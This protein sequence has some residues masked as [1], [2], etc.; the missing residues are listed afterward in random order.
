MPYDIRWDVSAG[1]RYHEPM[2]GSGSM[3]LKLKS[4]GF[5]KTRKKAFLSD[6]NSI[7]ISTMKVVSS[8]KYLAELIPMLRELQDK[9]PLDLPHPNPRNQ[10]KKVREKR[11]FYKKEID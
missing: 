8:K 10:D 1:Q 6:I 11:M 2:L 7:I 9:Y 5:I 4:C 3:F